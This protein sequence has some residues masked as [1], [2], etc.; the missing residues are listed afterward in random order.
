MAKV[1][2]TK[3]VAPGGYASAGVAVTMA[4]GDSVDGA[5]FVAQGN[6]LVI[7]RNTG[8]SPRTVTISSTADPYGRTKDITTES[9]AAG[10]I[11]VYG[12]FPQTGWVQS[13]GKIYLAASSTEVVFGVIRL[14]G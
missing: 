2:L 4:A 14:P 6:D 3:T 7:A 8:A 13:D 12:P 5:E 1:T 11:R 9:I 10:A